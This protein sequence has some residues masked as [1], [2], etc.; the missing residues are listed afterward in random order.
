MRFAHTLAVLAV[1]CGPWSA[2]EV[3][4]VADAIPAP[5]QA[6]GEP[7]F[8]PFKDGVRL[9]LLTDNQFVQDHVNQGLNHLHGGW[10]TEAARHFAAAMQADPDC[11]IAHWGM[12]MALL[13]PSPE[14][15]PARNAATDRLLMLVEQGK[16]SDLERGYAYGLMKYIEDGPLG[17]AEAFARV[18]RQFP[19]DIQAPIFE[20]IFS[21]GGFDE[22]GA[23]KPDQERS[24]RLLMALIEKHPE[25]TAPINALLTIR[26]DGGDLGERLELAR[27]LNTMQPGYAPYQHL[28]GHYE[29][30]CGNHAQAVR[31]FEESTRLYE[32]W[33]VENRAGVADCHDWVRSESYRIVAMSSRGQFDQAFAAARQLARTPVPQERMQSP[34]ARA[35][36]WEGQTLPA[37]LLLRRGNRGNAAEA[38]ISLPTADETRGLR[39]LSLAG[40]WVDG[41]RIALEARRVMDEGD[42]ADA[43]DVSAAL[44]LHGE[45]MADTQV[46]ASVGGERSAWNRAF[47]GLEVIAAETRGVLAMQGPEAG[48]RSAF[49]WFRGAVDRQLHATMMYPPAVLTP[50]AARL[51]DFHLLENNAALAVEVFE[52]AL[53][54][55]PN[56]M[57]ALIGLL[58]AAEA[59]GDEE[60]LEFAKRA[61]EALQVELED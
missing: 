19:N 55:F 9:L 50:M 33:M 29:W 54:M 60:K 37:R 27:N 12:V 35:L 21:R 6:L 47:R 44:T 49:N 56:D 38:Q 42:F 5:I 26:A 31:A 51:G 11:L 7:E 59:A 25:S 4:D 17:A 10:E 13:T 41:L 61:I 57:S 16:G 24:E 8:F 28:L 3:P 30:R 14:T 32:Q 18:A 43:R 39:D 20:A 40:W 48:R 1:A 36:Y 2:A 22:T 45:R 34:G 46:A 58:D 52:E 15:G 53:V 23:P